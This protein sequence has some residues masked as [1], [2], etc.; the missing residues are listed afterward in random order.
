M[1]MK[2]SKPFLELAGVSLRVHGKPAFRN[3]CWAFSH[4]QHWA[5]IGPN[6]SG[7]TLLA[8]AIAGELP[9][10]RGE[11]RYGFRAPAGKIPEDCIVL[12]SFQ[13]Q[14]ALAGEAPPA[15]RW[16]STEMDAAPTAEQ[17]LRQDSVEEVNPYE[18]LRRPLP[19]AA[20]YER[21]RRR[22]VRLLRIKPLMDRSLLSLSHGEMRK[23]LL[24]RAL[25]RRPRLLILDDVFCGLDVAFR[26]YLKSVLAEL[27]AAGSMRIL[28]LDTA[29]DNLPRGITHILLVDGLGIKAQGSVSSMTQHPEIRKLSLA[30]KSLKRHGRPQR[31]RQRPSEPE[32][33]TLMVVENAT[34]LYENRKIL[35][36]INWIIRRG[37]S[38]A[39]IGPNGSGKST[40][41]SLII[42]DN[43]QAYANSIYAF[44]RKRGSGESI[45][46][47]KKKIGYVSPE[48]HLRFPEDPTCLE[49]VL[50][51]FHESVRCYIP[52]SAKER[53]AAEKA[54]ARMGMLRFS[55]REFGSLSTGLQR[56]TLLARALVKS[57]DLLLLDEPCHGLDPF[58][59]GM[60]LKIIE[61]ML[62]GKETTLV[63]VTHRYDEIPR[64]IAK[65][66]ELKD[67]RV[68]QS[69]I[70]KNRT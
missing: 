10:A 70:L 15:A 69:R 55:H 25:L 7:K 39:L 62:C 48:L 45:W 2:P 6:G 19:A 36:A 66:L 34:V 50:S 22:T 54:L 24:A 63:Y 3:I 17:L 41:L 56:M 33:S 14:K 59:R 26:S 5:M 23:V 44:G 61:S 68:F 9:V 4:D 57:P 60:F 20:H 46:D 37:E 8:R 18:I 35:S 51:G 1:P 64:G 67:G 65:I 11:I 43:P 52:P 31:H 32:N 13:Q 28:F 47:L 27:M 21:L 12:F 38:W 30:P 58:H 16:L 29:V 53:G 42:G 40:L 49:T